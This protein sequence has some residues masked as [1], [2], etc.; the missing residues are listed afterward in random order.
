MRGCNNRAA[1][2]SHDA[3]APGQQL[4]TPGDPAA[5][6]AAAHTSLLAAAG[7][8]APL[9]TP[10]QLAQAA[11]ASAG[12]GRADASAAAEAP[13]S[14]QQQQMWGLMGF[15]GLFVDNFQLP[16]DAPEHADTA[17]DPL[18]AGR[19]AWASPLQ[20]D[21][22]LSSAPR[23]VAL[24]SSSSGAPDKPWADGRTAAGLLAAATA[25]AAAAQPPAASALS[26]AM[27]LVEGSQAAGI[28]GRG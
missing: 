6:A 10:A 12:G 19:V 7:V 2:C 16:P 13:A 9:A 18:A 5:A 22:A 23:Q 21:W 24:P 14:K 3:P 15:G 4:S 25:V 11:A 28:T 27:R 26:L 1:L 8:T 17:D 20:H